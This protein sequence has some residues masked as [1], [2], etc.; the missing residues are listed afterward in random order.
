MG[1]IFQNPGL[2][3][4]P[5]WYLIRAS[6]L[7]GF[8]RRTIIQGLRPIGGKYE[9]LSA[10]TKSRMQLRFYD[11][12]WLVTSH[13]VKRGSHLLKI[14]VVVLC[15]SCNGEQAPDCI[16]AAGEISRET[17][18]LPAFSK[19]TVLE[20]IRL[21]L[22]QGP[23]QQVEVETGANLR[24]EVKAEVQDGT[25]LIS[26]TNDCNFFRPYGLTTVYVTAPNITEI[27]SSTG[28][29]ISSS[30]TLNYQ[31]LTLYSES[32]L[33][34]A[35]ET[36]DGSFNLQLAAEHVTVVVNGIA[37]FKLK[38]TTA[39]LDIT[40]AAGDSRVEADE[41]IADTVKLNHRGSNDIL[42]NPRQSLSGIIRGTGDVISYNR[43]LSVAVEIVYK[44]KLI[45]RE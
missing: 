5:V 45:F 27:R 29:P 36:T 13:F 3:E 16:Q 43:P 23:A 2:Q 39:N 17:L 44:G 15:I 31:N 30:G 14:V 18:T 38:G 11:H 42:L 28:Y 6:F 35:T 19:I 10:I 20:N 1:Y 25:L 24:P 37:Y 8:I 32:F 33:N 40:I 21:V 9:P 4:S 34:P 22:K 26:D 41:L 12:F 7:Y